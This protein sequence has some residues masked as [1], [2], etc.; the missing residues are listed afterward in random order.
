LQIN[1]ELQLKNIDILLLVL[2]DLEVAAVYDS[3][4]RI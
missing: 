4:N 1:P 2:I 3:I